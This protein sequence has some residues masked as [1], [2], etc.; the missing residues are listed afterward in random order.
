M[1]YYLFCCDL[2]YHLRTV[3]ILGM[4]FNNSNLALCKIYLYIIISKMSDIFMC[5]IYTIEE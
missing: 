2:F 4:H 5:Y 1:S 3:S